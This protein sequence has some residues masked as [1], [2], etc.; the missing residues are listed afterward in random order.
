M[1]SEL[2]YRRRMLACQCPSDAVSCCAIALCKYAVPRGLTPVSSQA[3]TI[4]HGTLFACPKGDTACP[5]E[6]GASGVTVLKV[7]DTTVQDEIVELLGNLS[8][9][10]ITTLR[11]TRRAMVR[12]ALR[13]AEGN[14]SHAAQLLGVSRG[15]IYRYVRLPRSHLANTAT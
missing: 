3:E 10:Q 15:T 11:D 12:W 9:G 4:S 2:H 14:V 13:R 7:G 5:D 1:P 8:E 6:T